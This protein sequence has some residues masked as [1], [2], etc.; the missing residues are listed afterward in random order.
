[1]IVPHMHHVNS[2]RPYLR[3][4]FDQLWPEI[5]SIHGLG[6]FSAWYPYVKR[7]SILHQFSGR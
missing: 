6:W 5:V 4:Y 2:A 7:H 1:M 3:A